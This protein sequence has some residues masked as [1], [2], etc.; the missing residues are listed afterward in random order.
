MLPPMQSVR[1]C[2]LPVLCL[3]WL[4]LL[5]L[6]G[7]LAAAPPASTPSPS[8]AAPS[9]EEI[10]ERMLERA[11]TSAER[12]QGIGFAYTRRTVIEELDDREI[13]R[14]RKTREHAVTNLA[15]VAR[16]VLVRLDER[17]PTGREHRTD[18]QRESEN[19]RETR[20]RRGRRAGGPDFLD[21]SLLRR[22]DYVLEGE[23]LLG[24]RRVWVLN[25]EPKPVGKDA[26]ETADRF[27]A[28]LHGRLWVDVEEAELV[29]VE[30][31]LKS[32]LTVL[33]GLAASLTRIDFVIL[34]ERL[35]SGVWTN[36]RLQSYAEGRK[37]FSSFRMRME[38]EQEDFRELPVTPPR[39]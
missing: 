31:H 20:N 9:V 17:E 39:P 22:F 12:Q 3:R 27:L 32:P 30:S 29:K 11:R 5:G 14:E 18:Q 35:A 25:F 36:R 34:R 6:G 1:F 15:G 23:E 16:A 26:G 21:E 10:L 8:P 24:G 7:L 2:F 4:L 28:R 19:Q 33:G 13:V 38:V 37:V